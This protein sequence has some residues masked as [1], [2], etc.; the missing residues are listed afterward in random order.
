M[1]APLRVE[2]VHFHDAGIASERLRDA[3]Q[4]V[5]AQRKPGPRGMLAQFVVGKFVDAKVRQGYR[6]QPES[7]AR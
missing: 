5:D 6:M 3:A 4:L 1:L 7:A 2:R